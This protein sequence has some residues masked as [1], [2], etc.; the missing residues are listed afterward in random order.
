M[1]RAI[2]YKHQTSSAC[3]GVC[4]CK[5]KHQIDK[6]VGYELDKVTNFVTKIFSKV[7]GEYYNINRNRKEV[8]SVNGKVLGQIDKFVV[9]C[10]TLLCKLGNQIK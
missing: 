1:V 9:V 3:A 2:F 4:A 6:T 10:F 7:C 5:H 8:P